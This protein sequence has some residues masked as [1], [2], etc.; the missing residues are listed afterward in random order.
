MK[1][2][3]LSNINYPT[4]SLIRLFDFELEEIIQFRDRIQQIVIE[5]RNPLDL[6]EL[7]F[8][9]QINCGLIFHISSEDRGIE[10]LNG[11]DFICNLTVKS[12]ENLLGYLA[13]FCDDHLSGFQWLLYETNTPIELLLSQSGTW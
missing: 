1:A 9:E 13:P 11:T 4:D 2:E 3:Y 5:N 12:Y 6:S 8:I 10:K 7:K